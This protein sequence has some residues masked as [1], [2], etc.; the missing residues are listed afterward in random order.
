[1]ATLPFGPHGGLN[2][3]LI[4]R[5]LSPRAFALWSFGIA[6]CTALYCVAYN[7]AQGAHENPSEAV[8]WALA[9]VLPWL[10]AFEF[11]KRVLDDPEQY[12]ATVGVHFAAIILA[13]LFL[14]MTLEWLIAGEPGWAGWRPV[15]FAALRRVPGALFIASLLLLRPRLDQDGAGTAQRAAAPGSAF[16]LLPRQISWIKAAGNYLEIRSSRATVLVRMT[17]KHAE[18]ALTGEGF[19]RV[20]RSALVN[21]RHIAAVRTGKLYDEIRLADGN[22]LR[23]GGAYRARVTDAAP[24]LE[25]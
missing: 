20:H 3:A 15:W 7:M 4:Y 21:V 5:P 22:W 13:T 10:L 14:S 24:T 1:M 6:A 11:G 9:N 23:V 8:G 16:P 12:P 17:M 25:R 18:E 2:F 19:L